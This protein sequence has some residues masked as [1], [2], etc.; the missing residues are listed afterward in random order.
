LSGKFVLDRALARKQTGL[1]AGLEW[2][3]IYDSTDA[4]SADV[5]ATLTPNGFYDVIL[6]VVEPSGDMGINCTCGSTEE[7]VVVNYT[8][9]GTVNGEFSVG[10]VASS[11]GTSW[12]ELISNV[13]TTSANT[14]VELSSSMDVLLDARLSGSLRDHYLLAVLDPFAEVANA[15]GANDLCPLHNRCRFIELYR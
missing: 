11:D 3:V 13:R 8:T 2:R 10:L 4:A 1:A 6:M 15:S 9:T 7:S 12:G 14:S 5:P